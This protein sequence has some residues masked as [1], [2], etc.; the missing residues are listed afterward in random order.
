MFMRRN[1][2][3]KKFGRLTPI[4]E[5]KIGGVY[6]WL[7]SCSCGNKKSIIGSSLYSGST[8][9]CGC[10]FKEKRKTYYKTHGASKTRIYKIYRG[11]LNR[12]K[13][14]NVKCYK[15]YGG[16]GIKCLWNTFEDFYIDMGPSYKEGLTIDRIDV[17]GNYC[18]KNCQWIT[19]LKQAFNRRNSHF[20]TYNGKTQTMTEWS[21]E[22]GVKNATLWARIVQYGWSIEKALTYN[23]S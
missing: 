13:N 1:M 3:G 15:N 6:K 5:V 19:I 16:R 4:K 18:K 22:I 9:S 11:I 21:Y 8:K 10:L 7:C 23:R 12:C 2:L 14:K 20:L 17:N